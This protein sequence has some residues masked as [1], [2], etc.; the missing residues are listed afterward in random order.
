MVAESRGN[1]GEEFLALGVGN[2][3]IQ[4]ACSCNPFLSKLQVY[5]GKG[6]GREMCSDTVSL[7]SSLLTDYSQNQKSLPRKIPKGEEHG[8]FSRKFISWLLLGCSCV[9]PPA[10]TSV[11]STHLKGTVLAKS[12]PDPQP[13]L[14]GLSVH[15]T[16]TSKASA[17]KLPLLLRLY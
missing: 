4:V 5:Q 13:G 16:D 11:P 8:E 10:P 1:T 9:P 6:G 2:R 12:N 17:T 15:K 7:D 3:S 14:A